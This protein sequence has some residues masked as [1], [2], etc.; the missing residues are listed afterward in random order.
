MHAGFVPMYDTNPSATTFDTTITRVCNAG[1]VPQSYWHN[2]DC[3]S[4]VPVG[5][6]V[7]LPTVKEVGE[8]LTLEYCILIQKY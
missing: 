3:A 6:N 8:F 1:N 7:L 5:D 2:S 4:V